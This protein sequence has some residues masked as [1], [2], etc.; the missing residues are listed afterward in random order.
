MVAYIDAQR[1][2]YG[3]EPMCAV[4]PIAPAT[5]YRHRRQQREPATVSLRTQRDIWLKTEIRRVWEANFGVYGARKVWRQLQR[6]GL[7]WSPVAPWS[8]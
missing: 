7:R 6:D 8:D 1:A 5:Y 2:T 4:L 3:V